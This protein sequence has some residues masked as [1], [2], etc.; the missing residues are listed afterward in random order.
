ML[1]LGFIGAGTVG[2]A[3]ALRLSEKGYPVV[4]VSSRSHTSAEKLAQ[5]IPGCRAEHDNQVVAD[6]AELVLIT[7]PDDAIPRVA[8][9]TK[10]RARQSVVHCSGAD[11]TATLE[12][13]RKVGAHVGAFHPLQTFA[14]AQQAIENLPGSTFAIEAEEPL[15]SVLKDM[16]AALGGH[17]IE[18]RAEDKVVYHA[19]AVMACNYL[20]TLVKLATDL[21][22][23]FGVPPQE[24]TR[25]LLPLLSGTV[26]NIET[27]GIPRC[28]TG[29]IA[30]GDAGTIRKHL[31]ALEKVAPELLAVY[32]E[33]GRQTIPVALGKGRINQRQ[34]EELNTLLGEPSLAGSQR[35][36]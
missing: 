15:L 23:S 21:W 4:A 2:S 3:L 35:K 25:A 32:R 11:S 33:L 8:A 1:R 12:P 6:R 13:A 28:L 17:S 27:V 31:D 16:A 9:E 29:P 7:T 19:A 20:V 18:L 14:S 5:A 36:G 26:H 10:W 30:R 34:A 24:A 22:Q